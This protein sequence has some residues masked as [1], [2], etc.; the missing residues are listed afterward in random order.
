MRILQYILSRR[1]TQAIDALI[2]NVYTSEA[3]LK[4]MDK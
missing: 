4:D 3:T 1:Y 2:L